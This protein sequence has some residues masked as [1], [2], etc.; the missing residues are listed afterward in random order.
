MKVKEAREIAKKTILKSIGIAYYNIA[1][2]NDYTDE[3]KEAII[4][5]INSYGSKACRSLGA[6]YITY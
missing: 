6:D 5:Y 4:F 1:D 2:C 3:E